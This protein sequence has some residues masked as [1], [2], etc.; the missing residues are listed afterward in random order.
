M[1]PACAEEATERQNSN[2]VKLITSGPEDR[3]DRPTWA[4]GRWRMTARS[5][6]WN[7]YREAPAVVMGHYWRLDARAKPGEI[8]GDWDYPLGDCGPYEWMGP[9]RNVFCVDY[10][11]GGRYAERARGGA[12]PFQTRLAALRWPERELQFDDGERRT[13]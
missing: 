2:P 6:W 9:L 8:T 4:G 13:L 7:Q 5:R 10:S 1:L 3:S 12:P 11:V